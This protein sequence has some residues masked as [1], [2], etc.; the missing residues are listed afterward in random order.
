MFSIKCSVVFLII[1]G[2]NYNDDYIV[3]VRNN[4]LNSNS[5]FEFLKIL[6]L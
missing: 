1:K 2:I 3:V 6:E 5:F 4:K